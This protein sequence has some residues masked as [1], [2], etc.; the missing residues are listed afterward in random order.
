VGR[1]VLAARAV[2]VPDG[3]KTEERRKV[4]YKA[5]PRR[6]EIHPCRIPKG[7]KGHTGERCP[8]PEDVEE[9]EPVEP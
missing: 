2:P 4:T 3:T 9:A 8:E 6:I 1:S 5:R 7:E